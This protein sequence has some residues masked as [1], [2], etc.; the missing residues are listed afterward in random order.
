[1]IPFFAYERYNRYME[2]LL[3]IVIVG[4]F[5]YMFYGP[6]TKSAK[7]DDKKGDKK[8]GKKEEKH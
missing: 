1:M 2:N 8:G 5:A 6:H 7:K 3:L 4:V